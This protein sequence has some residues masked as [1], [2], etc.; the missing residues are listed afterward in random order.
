MA[1]M[2]GIVKKSLLS[3]YSKIN[4]GGLIAINIREDDEL[5]GAQL[6]D[7]KQEVVLVTRRGLSIRFSEDD[8]R[9]TGRNTMGVRGVSL[10]HDDRVI[11]M[12]PIVE[13]LNLLVVSE[14]GF[15]K[16]TEME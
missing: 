5:V 2:E 11:G 1:T 12:A 6:T 16:R 10:R 14:N 15:G 4:K 8:V 13:G 3:D 7:G 9:S